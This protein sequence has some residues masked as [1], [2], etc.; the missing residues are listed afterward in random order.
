MTGL[1]TATAGLTARGR[2]ALALW[3]AALV[4]AP[5]FV[6]G[7]VLSVLTLVLWFAYV[8]QAW[9]VMM[10]FAGQL[11]L[12][13]ALYVGLGAYAGAALS[14][15]FGIGPWLGVWVGMALAAAAGGVIGVLGFRF[16]IRGVYF[17]LLTIAFA[18][19]TRIGFDH[20][21]WI[22]GSGGLFLPAGGFSPRVY[23]GIMLVL[24]LLALAL[25]RALLHS[26][27][28]YFW[29]AVREDQEAAQ[30]VGIDVTR[31]KLAAVVISAAMT[32]PAGVFYAFY[33]NNLFPE[34]VFSV[35]R[36]IEVILA[37][38]IG[39]IGTLFGPIF[40]AFV[41]TPLGEILGWLIERAGI[42]APGAKQ[43][44]Q[45]L[46]LIAIVVFRPEGLWP[47]AARRLGLTVRPE[48]LP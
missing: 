31:A 14:V 17:A 10:G 44:F 43:I 42:T 1:E 39:G 19:F 46:A 23:Y 35:G 15:H 41:L 16:A 20:I 36:S 34:Q 18:E 25:C 33:Y 38:V 29:Q 30:A 28:G 37:P 9:N 12:G 6:G 45:G 24:V 8:G 48:D 11:S 22:G 27:L 47:W 2:A 5:L 13:H 21:G 3:I 26:R 32:A 7:Y 40:G 4:L